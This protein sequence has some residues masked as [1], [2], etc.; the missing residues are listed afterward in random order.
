MHFEQYVVSCGESK[1]EIKLCKYGKF[2]HHLVKTMQ[3]K[4][5]GRKLEFFDIQNIRVFFTSFMCT[6]IPVQNNIMIELE[7]IVYMTDMP[8]TSEEL[9]GEYGLHAWIVDLEQHVMITEVYCQ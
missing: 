6:V 2:V 5:S 4:C 1:V 8:Y 7:A 3:T 9:L